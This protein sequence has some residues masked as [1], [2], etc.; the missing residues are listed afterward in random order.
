VQSAG[1]IEG[2][3]AGETAG[4]TA[5]GPRTRLTAGQRRESILEA[6]AEV[7]AAAGYR[8]AK[9]SDVASR[10][11]VTEPVIFQNFGSKAALFAAVL[12]RVTT[13]SHAELD[14]LAGEHG[15]VGDLLA[16]ILGPAGGEDR[17][18]PGAHRGI[19][20]DAAALIADPGAGEAAT[21][22]ARVIAGHLAG[23]LR[24]GQASGDIRPDLD[25]E[26]AA[27]LLLSVLATRSLRAAAA[28]P[29]D[30]E[31]AVADLTLRTL[32]AGPA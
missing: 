29:A 4:K 8:A 25:P 24:H 28:P 30:V 31:A 3:T 15:P 18:G 10:V 26:P 21:G 20:A 5:A 13:G 27:W 23:L 2:K 9:M 12:E 11:G 16:H 32:R 6:A 19:L 7:F 1:K 17:H 22:A 14:A